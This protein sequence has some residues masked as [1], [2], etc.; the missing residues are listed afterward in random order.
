ML[1]LFDQGAPEPAPAAFNLAAYVLAAGLAT[2]EKIALQVVGATGAERWSYAALTDA[3]RGTG[4]GLRALGL[5]PGDRVLLRLSNSVDFPIVYLGAIAAGLIPVPTSSQLT[6][7]EVTA[8]GAEIRPALIAASDG[9]SLP[10]APDCPVL[11]GAALTALRATAPCDYAMGDP[12]RLAYIIYTSGSSGRPRAVMHAHRAVWARRMMYRGWYDLQPFDR[13]LHAGAFNWTYTLGT[14]LMDPWAM[15]ATAL[16]P[17]AGTEPR[18]LPLLLKRYD[19]TIFAAAPGVYRQMLRH[20]AKFDLPRLRHGLSAG[21]KLPATI[22]HGWENA[23]GTE[24]HEALGMSECSTFISAAPGHPAPE[25][26]SGFPQP[27][28]RIAV[29]GDDGQPVARGEAGILAI[30]RRD[31]GLFLGYLGAEEETAQ[32][33]SGE[34]FLTGDTVA[35]DAANAVTYLG[36]GDDMMN[37]GGYRV[38]PLEVEHAMAHCPGIT[39]CAAVEVT[40]KADTSVIALFYTGDA[41]DEAA[42][43]AHAAAHLARYKQPRLYLHHDVLPRGPNN[44]LSRRALRLAYEARMTAPQNGETA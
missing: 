1:S 33:M 32:K 9:V 26:A 8:I 11:S 31:P 28:R 30:S 22:R 7:P 36:R 15:G 44:K 10:E 6:V 14:G 5:S 41:Q 23:T 13:L 40:V 12:D 35:M 27:G 34:W 18:Q 3:V 4:A 16:I 24:V 37:A 38:S 25:G 21:E 43:A 19:A 29:L 2:P 17:A 42:L 20:H 39:D